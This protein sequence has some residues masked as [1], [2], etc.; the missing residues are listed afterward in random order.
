MT[1]IYD[2][3]N[4]INDSF[5][6]PEPFTSSG[7]GSILSI[8]ERSI[9]EDFGRIVKD[10]L[11]EILEDLFEQY[12]GTKCD[13]NTQ[14]RNM[15]IRHICLIT[16]LYNESDTASKSR[17]K[18][19]EPNE[20]DTSRLFS[21]EVNSVFRDCMGQFIENIT[22]IFQQL[23]MFADETARIEILEK[24]AESFDVSFEPFTKTAGVRNE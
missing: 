12:N 20:D 23:T 19:N 16:H 21:D 3:P 24:I 2:L 10:Q 13:L 6:G 9:P 5:K 22:D 8:P 17:K 1:N 18:K 14:D 11:R 4:S 15:L 7:S